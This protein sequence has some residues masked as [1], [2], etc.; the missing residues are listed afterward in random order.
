MLSSQSFLLALFQGQSY[1]IFTTHLRQKHTL[2]TQVCKK[3][4][5]SRGDILSKPSGRNQ[6]HAT[7]TWKVMFGGKTRRMIRV[8]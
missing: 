7:F 3:Q 5:A 2:L 8:C 1:L 6:I 4:Y